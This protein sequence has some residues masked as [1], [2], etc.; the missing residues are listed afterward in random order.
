VTSLPP[1][2]IEVGRGV[3]RE[4]YGAAAGVE[5]AAEAMA[6]LRVHAPSA[7]M[8]LASPRHDLTEVVRGVRQVTGEVPLVGASAALQICD[9][10][11]EGSV[12]VT[13]LASPFLTMRVGLGE[14]V[15]QDWSRAIE[16]AIA[17]P[18]LRP[19]FEQATD[20]WQRLRH[21]GRDAFACVFGPGPTSSAPTRSYNIV[22]AL[23]RRSLGKLP[24]FGA[25]ASDELA[26]QCNYVM[27]NDR[28]V[29]DGLA[30]AL[31]ETELRFGAAFAHGLHPAA[32]AMR[33]TSAQ[34][35]VV[36]TLN[37]RPAADV[38]AAEL[39]TTRAAIEGCFIAIATKTML[40]TPGPLGSYNPN[41]PNFVTEEGGIQFDIPIPPGTDIYRLVADAETCATAGRDA[42]S[43]ASARARTSRPAMVLTSCCV[44]RTILFGES[45]K[46][47]IDSLAGMLSGTPLVGFF[48]Y[49][50]ANSGDDGVTQAVSAIVGVLIIADELSQSAQVA[51]EN[52][53]L[54]GH[55]EALLQS[56]EQRVRERT[57]EL[58]DKNHELRELPRRIQ[59]LILPRCAAAPSI[60]IGARMTT[61]EEVGGDYYDV[62]PVADGAWIA[63]GDVSG[64]GL[65][66]G[67][68]TFMLQSAMAT[69]TAACPHARPRELVSL[70]NTVLYK[71]IRERLGSDDHVTFVLMRVFE[72][73]R[74][75]FAG[76]HEEL[77]IR[78]ARTG[79]CETVSTLGTWLGAIPDIS[80]TTVDSELRLDVG[81]LLVAYTDGII[82]ARN[83]TDEM[84][85][86]ERLRSE[87]VVAGA[88]S[89]GEVCD[90]LWAKVHD[91]CAS[92]EDDAS[93]VLVRF[94]GVR[95]P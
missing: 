19:F 71:N 23:K 45:A 38:L 1:K 12:V 50:A 70:L 44:L 5:A 41:P 74:V 77:L 24:I 29:A 25:S 16:E 65:Q 53:Q 10:V 94:D 95:W 60:T 82:E 88:G 78:R 73:G 76:N 59:T 52:A 33:V 27:V 61:A 64:H 80:S 3:R 49:G 66:A 85:G 32:A 67:L 26:F 84:F 14:H 6:A 11:H 54:R 42:L 30:V 9:G 87:I 2:L 18:G 13:V 7:V 86:L 39:G 34:G 35:N 81:D 90:H 8:V 37:G 28:V 93:L 46:R 51:R 79:A 15:S 83:D 92:P 21:D 40:G 69:L 56:L 4:P 48:D 55:T 20:P 58:A 68:I 47:E 31:F 75:V 89:P 63:V 72:D 91:W 36:L 22:E 43:K 17:A 57:Q 62:I